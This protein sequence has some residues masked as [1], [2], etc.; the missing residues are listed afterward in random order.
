MPIKKQPNKPDAKD[1]RRYPRVDKNVAIK[2]KDQDADFV[3]ETKNLSCIGAYAQ[4]DTYI[5]ILTKLRVTLLLPR[6]RNVKEAR[7]ITCEGTVVRVERRGAPPEPNKYHIAIYFNEISKNDMKHIDAY[8]KNQLPS[9]PSGKTSLFAK[10]S[11]DALP[12]H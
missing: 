4:I 1:R 12:K 9:P 10:T 8:V 3:T 5:P 2:L 11:K 6:Q 7:H